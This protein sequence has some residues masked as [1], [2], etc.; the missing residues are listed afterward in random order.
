MEPL[1]EEGQDVFLGVI[2]HGGDLL[3]AAVELRLVGRQ[4]GGG[5]ELR[6]LA[7]VV[8]T[9]NPERAELARDPLVAPPAALGRTSAA[10]RA[11]DA[12]G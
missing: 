8:A 3:H 6:A 10:P 11:G 2:E 12:G 9:L 7:L 4:D 1:L 5:V